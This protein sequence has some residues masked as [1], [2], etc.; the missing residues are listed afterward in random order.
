M[1]F[2]D[3]KSF[4]LFSY[5]LLCWE[6]YLKLVEIPVPFKEVCLNGIPAGDA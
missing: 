4:V 5:S 6:I 2:L 3:K 1:G